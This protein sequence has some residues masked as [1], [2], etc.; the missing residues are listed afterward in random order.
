[1]TKFRGPGNTWRKEREHLKLNCWWSFQDLRDKQFM[2]WP[3]EHNK[4]PEDVPK[5][6]LKT[7]KFLDN[8]WNSLELGSRVKLEGKRF[9]YWGMME[10]LSK[11]EKAPILEHIQECLNKK[12]AL[13]KEV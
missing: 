3:Y 12:L 5:G 6:E 1:M 10:P 4:D 2:F 8:W 11:E 9:I 13:L 7:E